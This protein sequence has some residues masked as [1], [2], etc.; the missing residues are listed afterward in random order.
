MCSLFSRKF[1][2]QEIWATTG[3]ADRITHGDDITAPKTRGD[4]EAVGTRL[5]LRGADSEPAGHGQP[6]GQWKERPPTPGSEAGDRRMM[7][8]NGTWALDK[9]SGMIPSDLP[10]RKTREQAGDVRGFSAQSDPRPEGQK[11]KDRERKSDRDN[12]REHAFS[13]FL[14]ADMCILQGQSRKTAG[15]CVL[16]SKDNE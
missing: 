15:R 3:L 6:C 1:T 7:K 12:N 14:T 16:I 9:A 8:S 5:S 11:E 4:E 2:N 13:F 10:R